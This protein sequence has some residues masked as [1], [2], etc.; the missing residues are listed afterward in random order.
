MKPKVEWIEVDLSRSREELPKPL[1]YQSGGSFWVITD[2]GI[3]G[4]KMHLEHWTGE[5][6]LRVNNDRITHFAECEYP[7][8]PGNQ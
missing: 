5:E 8:Y 6:F 1:N 3:H 7:E 4:K 2:G